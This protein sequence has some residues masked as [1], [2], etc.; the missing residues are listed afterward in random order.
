MNAD[1]HRAKAEAIEQSLARC[2]T[3]DYETVIEA[4]MLAGTHW[5]NLALHAMELLPDDHDAMHAE[6]LTVGERRKIACVL[7]AALAAIDTIESLRTPY[8][9]GDLPGGAQAAQR[10]LGSLAELKRAAMHAWTR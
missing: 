10:A 8:V 9:R 2:T 6:F 5:F 4:C 3:A 1:A 7:P